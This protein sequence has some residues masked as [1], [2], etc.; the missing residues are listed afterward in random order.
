MHM[1][2]GSRLGGQKIIKMY[3]APRNWY[4]AWLVYTGRTEEEAPQSDCTFPIWTT[5]KRLPDQRVHSW[6][7]N[8]K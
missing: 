8:I 1:S 7:K 4:E 2:F 5:T 3:K 6:A